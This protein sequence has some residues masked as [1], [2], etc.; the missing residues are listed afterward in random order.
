MTPDRDTDAV[1]M[2]HTT[3]SRDPCRRAVDVIVGSVLCL[4]VL[5]VLLAAVAG[6]A[7]TLRAWPLFTQ[8]RVGRGGRR[9]RFVKIRTL[10]PQVPAYT[11]K[12]S[13]RDA[14]IRRFCRFLRNTH[15]DE[16]PQ[17][18]LVV[19]G[20]M[21][22]FGPRPEMPFL[23]EDLDPGF[24]RRRTEVRPGCTGLWQI[25]E[26]CSGL[27][28]EAP[29]YDEVYLRNRGARL[30]AWIL[31]HTLRKLTRSG[32][33]VSL[34]QIPDRVLVATGADGDLDSGGAPVQATDGFTT[35]PV[36]SGS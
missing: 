12:F 35:A 5:P 4:L 1:P 3:I 32:H 16:L 13:L 15:L 20:S 23:H 22:L 25:S 14:E 28:Q 6:S 31:W 27:I 7:L 8:D 9:F 11:D 30:D 18:Y 10:S 33:R 19:G 24:A 26:A 34:D 17:L 36:T 21:S 29:Q 2:R